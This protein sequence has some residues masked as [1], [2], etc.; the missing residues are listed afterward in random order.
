M[1]QLPSLIDKRFLDIGSGSGLFSLA[2][3]RLGAKVHSF[4]YDPHSVACTLELKRRYFPDDRDWTIDQG[5]ALDVDYLKS[6]GTYDIVY[7]WGVLHHTGHMWQALENVQMTVAPR[8]RL[9][10]AIYND[11]GIKS[12]LWKR[13]KEIFCSGAIG[14]ASVVSI[15]IPYYI[16]R[17]VAVDL[18]RKKNP[19]RRYGESRER[20]MYLVTDW[21]DWLGG[22]PFE[23]AKADD[24]INYFKQRGFIL[25]KFKSVQKNRGN[26]EFVFQRV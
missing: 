17:G 16:A 12:I 21:L 25:L 13:I 19:F 10:I 14:K 4:D 6:L 15:F 23:V 7:S 11:Q 8:G 22:L 5:S 3:R 24:I 26:N 9:F 2:A 20:G 18:I 1:L